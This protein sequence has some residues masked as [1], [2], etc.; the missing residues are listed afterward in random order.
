MPAILAYLLNLFPSS[1]HFAEQ[2]VGGGEEAEAYPENAEYWDA[3]LSLALSG[4][5]KCD[6]K[7]GLQM[8]CLTLLMI[9]VRPK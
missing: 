4:L 2:G 1:A 7:L 9:A 3:V 5:E 6:W 8:G